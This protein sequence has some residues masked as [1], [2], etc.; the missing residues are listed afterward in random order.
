[1]RAKPTRLSA[2]EVITIQDRL[3]AAMIALDLCGQDDLSDQIK[4]IYEE[5]A[6][7]AFEEQS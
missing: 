6:R 3:R 1:M 2:P 5:V 4:S 7:R